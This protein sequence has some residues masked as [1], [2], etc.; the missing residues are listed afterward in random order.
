MLGHKLVQILAPEHEVYATIRGTS[1]RISNCSGLFRGARIIDDLCVDSNDS[2]VPVLDRYRPDVVVNCIGIVKQLPAAC[3]PVAAISINALL[4]H[5]LQR[6]VGDRGGRFIH[7]STDCV[8]S[9]TQGRYRESD[10]PDATDLYGKTKALGEPSGANCLTIRTSI[11]GRELF[12]RSG[13][14]EWFLAHRG[15]TVSGYRYA[16]FSGLTTLALSRILD[17]V[18]SSHPQLAGLYHA[19]AS[20][21]DKYSLLTLIQRSASVPIR[22]VQEDSVACDRSLDGSR[23]EQATGVRVPDWETM[24]ADLAEDITQYEG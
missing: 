3:D 22:V 14:L 18:I 11:I 23:F 20:P 16:I 2:I 15:G 12:R 24:I 9:G 7:I 10:V 6:L 19:A 13:L 8:F 17:T 21:I 5:R 4:P 1:S